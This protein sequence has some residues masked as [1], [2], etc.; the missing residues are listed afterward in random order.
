MKSLSRVRP[1][2]CDPWTAAHQTPPSTGFSRQEYW[3]GVLLPSPSVWTTICQLISVQSLSLLDSL[4]L[5]GNCSTPG[6]PVHHQLPENAQTHVHPVGDAF[7]PS[8]PLVISSPPAFNVPA[9]Q[10]VLTSGSF[11]ISQFFA[12]GGQRIGASASASV[13]PMNIQD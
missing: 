1:M 6:F 12:S 2:L 5:H 3:S 4:R 7:Q 11:P 13:L 10:S 8:Q 9:F